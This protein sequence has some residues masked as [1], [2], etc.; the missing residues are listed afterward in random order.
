MNCGRRWNPRSKGC[1][2]AALI[3]ILILIAL[4]AAIFD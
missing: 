2:C 1:G 3:F 4:L